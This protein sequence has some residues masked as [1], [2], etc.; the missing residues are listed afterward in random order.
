M[1]REKEKSKRRVK[2]HKVEQKGRKNNQNTNSECP[3]TKEL[4]KRKRGGKRKE[5]IQKYDISVSGNTSD[6]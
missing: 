4:Q 5:I 1:D 2:K 6:L 3:T